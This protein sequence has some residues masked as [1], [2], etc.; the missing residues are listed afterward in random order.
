MV[1]PLYRYSRDEILPVTRTTMAAESIRERD[2]LQRLL[3][4]RIE[5]I[6]DG[7]LVIAEEYSLFQD[8]RRRV[9][10]LAIDRSGNLVVIELKRTDDGGHMELQ[11]LRYA[12]M[13]S[14]ITLDHLVDVY[15][16]AQA[17]S[18][19][20][21]RESILGWIDETVEELPNHVRIVLVSADFSTEITSTVLWLNENYSTDISCFRI[22]AYR[23]DS[24]VLLD[25]QQ[26]IPLPE[27]KDFQI[28]QRQKGAAA[29]AGRTAGRDFTQYN[30]SVGS[31]VLSNLSKQ[32]A[33][34]LA[35]KKLYQS[36]IA[37]ERI[38]SATYS[39]R[40]MA[41]HPAEGESLVEAFKREYPNVSPSHR[42]FDLEI[43][44]AQGAWVIPRFGGRDTELL[45][46]SLAA[47]AAPLVEFEW[48]RALSTVV[49]DLT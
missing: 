31:A 49:P 1:M 27:A 29:T 2:D 6:D 24:D 26:I 22:V 10:I 34:K 20:E 17:L 32:A 21:A 12:A 40:W 13:V 14:T 28:Q 16:E 11:A 38:Q 3:V 18:D 37:L 39:N 30:I 23:L 9:D 8:S 45:L 36:G 33:I 48:N 43:R 35:I 46:E 5:V 15:A 44:D 4:K 42:W 25:L 19:T 47:I 41:V 7:L